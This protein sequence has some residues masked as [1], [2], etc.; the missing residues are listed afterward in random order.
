MRL[1]VKVGC[2]GCTMLSIPR[3]G[4]GVVGSGRKLWPAGGRYRRRRRP[5]RLYPPLRRCRRV[6]PD[7]RSLWLVLGSGGYSH[8]WI[9]SHG[10]QWGG[11]VRSS[12]Q[13]LCP[14]AGSVSVTLTL[15]GAI[16]FLEALPKSFFTPTS[17]RFGPRSIGL[18]LVVVPSFG[19]GCLYSLLGFSLGCPLINHVVVWF[20]A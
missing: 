8:G 20:L 3:R 16:Y 7:T 18:C 2:V 1:G 4:G 11:G 14:D 5:R 10:V 17:G 12:W 6:H 15:A 13:K 19:W 9:P